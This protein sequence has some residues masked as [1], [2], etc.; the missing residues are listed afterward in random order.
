MLLQPWNFICEIDLHLSFRERFTCF[1][2]QVPLTT[3]SQRH[4][5]GLGLV[6]LF[7]KIALPSRIGNQHRLV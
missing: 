3:S 4:A 7:P 6:L 2:S 1:E 5:N